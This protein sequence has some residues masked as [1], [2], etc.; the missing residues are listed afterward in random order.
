MVLEEQT[1]EWYMGV[2][3]KAHGTSLDAYNQVWTYCGRQVEMLSAMWDTPKCRDCL[4]VQNALGRGRLKDKY[5][6]EHTEKLEGDDATA[7]EIVERI[8][9]DDEDD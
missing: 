9:G 3:G 2:D 7:D 5:D 1:T 4:A 6:I 8:T